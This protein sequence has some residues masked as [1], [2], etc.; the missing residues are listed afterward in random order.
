[1][2]VYICMYISIYK[3]IYIY[4]YIYIERE[5]TRVCPI[6]VDPICAQ[7]TDYAA[8]PEVP[9]RSSRMC[10]R[11]P[12]VRLSS[13][14][15]IIITIIIMIIIIIIIIIIMNVIITTGSAQ[16]EHG[17]ERIRHNADLV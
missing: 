8:P 2:C 17:S 14:G 16:I 9:T 1:M 11:W 7:P 15:A 5:H 10:T 4:I 12:L 3:Y 6:S 13:D